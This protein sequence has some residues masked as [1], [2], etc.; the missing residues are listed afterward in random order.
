MMPDRLGLVGIQGR[1][2][3]P[4]IGTAVPLAGRVIRVVFDVDGDH[5][6]RHLTI[7]QYGLGLGLR[8]AWALAQACQPGFSVHSRHEGITQSFLL[9]AR[10]FRADRVGHFLQ[11][12][13]CGCGFGGGQFCSDAG[14]FAG[15]TIGDGAESFGEFS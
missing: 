9:T 7:R 3:L 6:Q 5:R 8:A 1:R 13:P 14:Q 12:L 10:I 15:G 4:R 2:S 11:E